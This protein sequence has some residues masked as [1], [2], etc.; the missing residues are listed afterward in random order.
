[1]NMA[2]MTGSGWAVRANSG[3]GSA[4]AVWGLRLKVRNGTGDG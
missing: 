2:W 3:L 4:S 1:M